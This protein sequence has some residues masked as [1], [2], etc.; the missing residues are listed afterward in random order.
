ME[1]EVRVLEKIQQPSY[2][3]NPRKDDN[4]SEI[5]QEQRLKVRWLGKFRRYIPRVPCRRMKDAKYLTEN[6]IFEILGMCKN[7][8]LTLYQLMIPCS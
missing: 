5:N 2:K 1:N 4:M 3:N 6:F 7:N 8:E